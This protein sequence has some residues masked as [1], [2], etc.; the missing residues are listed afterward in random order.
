MSLCSLARVYNKKEEEVVQSSKGEEQGLEE[1]V[2]PL[3]IRC[4]FQAPVTHSWP[5]P[6]D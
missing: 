3:R 1:G 4:L 5:S 2:D 6:A